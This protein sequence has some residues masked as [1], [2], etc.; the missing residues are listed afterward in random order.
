MGG[1]VIRIHLADG[2]PTGIKH[3][4]LIGWT[5]Q[6]IVCPRGRV[7]ELFQREWEAEVG[8]PGVYILFGE[9]EEERTPLAYIGEAENVRERLRNHVSNKSFWDR[10]VFF[11]SKDENL[12]KAHVK[13]LESRMVELAKRAGRTPLENGNAPQQPRLPRADRDATEEFLDHARL[14]LAALGFPLL[15]PPHA[16]RAQPLHAGRVSQGEGGAEAPAAEA[17]AAEAPAAEASAASGGPLADVRLRFRLPKH[18]V[19]AVGAVTDEGFVV[20]AGSLGAGVTRES[21]SK[22]WTELRDELI[23]QGKLQVDGEQLRFVQDVLFRS[24]SAAAAVVAGGSRNGR[25][26]WRDEESGRT[27]NQLEAARL[28]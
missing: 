17:P 10:V 1:R 23:D 16:G 8:R 18:G 6:A 13:Y 21:L 15:Q 14:L 25:E 2:S 11:T 28:G 4:E 24:P 20:F 3:A 19:D 26:V 7:G 9:H 27:L 22:G 5:G 12:T